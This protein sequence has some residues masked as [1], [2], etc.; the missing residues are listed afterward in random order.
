MIK[1]MKYVAI[2]CI[3]LAYASAGFAVA[4]N[5]KV[6]SDPTGRY[7]SYGI[8]TVQIN[9]AAGTSILN[10]SMCS[11]PGPNIPTQ[12]NCSLASAVTSGKYIANIALQFQ[13]PN[14]PTANCVNTPF[15]AK[16]QTYT[17][18][19]LHINILNGGT[20]VLRLRNS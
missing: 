18:P 5:L 2:P 17:N 10:P 7:D 8:V 20:C 12:I 1:I 15:V 16:N 11:G 6:I 3:A 13:T 9:N 4:T 19:T 14:D